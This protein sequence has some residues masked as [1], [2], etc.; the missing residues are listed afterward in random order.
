[1]HKKIDD[2]LR[3]G[4]PRRSFGEDGSIEEKVFFVCF[5][6]RLNKIYDY[7]DGIYLTA[8]LYCTRRFRITCIIEGWNEERLGGLEAVDSI[9]AS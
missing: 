1:M 6:L 7:T 2:F 3:S 9:L 4:L 5:C 8:R